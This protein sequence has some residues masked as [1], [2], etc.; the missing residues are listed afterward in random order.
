MFA[1]QATQREAELNSSSSKTSPLTFWFI[2]S[3]LWFSIQ[4]TAEAAR[5]LFPGSAVYDFS[6]ALIIYDF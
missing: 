1:E 6:H 4:N 2:N 5:S 3:L